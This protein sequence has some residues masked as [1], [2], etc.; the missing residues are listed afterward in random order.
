MRS[1]QEI[2]A[3]VVD[4]YLSEANNAIH[5]D[6]MACT[7]CGQI[8]ANGPHGMPN[9]VQAG[10]AFSAGFK[11]LVNRIGPVHLING[12]PEHDSEFSKAPC[13]ICGDHLHGPR[14]AIVAVDPQKLKKLKI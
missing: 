9:E 7:D 12:A 4:Q 10:A 13:D 8:V 2:A 11:N 6:L 1:L 5:H 3:Y 14:M